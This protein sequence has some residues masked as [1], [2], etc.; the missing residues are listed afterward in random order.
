MN[1]FING[2]SFMKVVTGG[3]CTLN[4]SHI[5]KRCVRNMPQILNAARFFYKEL[6]AKLVGLYTESKL[7][8]VSI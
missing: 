3:G 4:A 2:Y 7:Y 1:F 6:N 5:C 8:D